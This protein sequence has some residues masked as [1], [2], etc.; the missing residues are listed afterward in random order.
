MLVRS[1]GREPTAKYAY[2]Y[3]DVNMGHV[4]TNKQM[5]PKPWNVTATK[6]GLVP[7]VKFLIATIVSTADV[8][9]P[10]VAFA[11]MVGWET[12][13]NSA[14]N[15]PDACMVTVATIPILVYAKMDMRDISVMYQSAKTLVFMVFVLRAILVKI[16]FAFVKLD[17]KMLHVS[18]VFLIGIVPT[19]N[20][21]LVT[22]PMNASVHLTPRIRKD[23][24]T[25]N[26]SIT[27]G[28]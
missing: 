9:A 16:T 13:V 5:N 11:M 17:G 20:R 22:C 14:Q 6:I 21:M 28:S 25:M 4:L 18:N 24:A 15:C 3:L 7:T 10:T 1:D 2:L 19:R 26:F 23:Y 27:K 12:L 8:K